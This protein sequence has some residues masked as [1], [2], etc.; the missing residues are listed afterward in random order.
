MT[1]EFKVILSQFNKLPL[2]SLKVGT[3]A[4]NC[5]DTNDHRKYVKKNVLTCTLLNDP[6]KK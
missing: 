2:A 1:D 4:V 5:D 3:A 6:S